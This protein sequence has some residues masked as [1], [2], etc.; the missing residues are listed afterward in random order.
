MNINMGLETGFVKY[1]FY[2]PLTIV[3][4]ASMYVYGGLLVTF[5]NTFLE[6]FSGNYINAFLEYFLYS[7]LPPTSLEQ[8]LFQVI[9]GTFIAGIKWYIA[10]TL[11]K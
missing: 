11:I 10:M 9:F 4:F 8:I 2:T 7:A 1:L 5:F 3:G 6:I